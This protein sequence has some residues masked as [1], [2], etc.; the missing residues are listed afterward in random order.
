VRRWR[1]ACLAHLAAQQVTEERIV[2]LCYDYARGAGNGALLPGRRPVLV[3]VRARLGEPSLAA[4]GQVRSRRAPD[5]ELGL[6][7]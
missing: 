1:D 3:R 7:G 2:K 5:E 6:T 4:A